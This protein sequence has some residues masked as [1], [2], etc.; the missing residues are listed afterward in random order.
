MLPLFCIRTGD[1]LHLRIIPG[2]SYTVELIRGPSGYG[3]SIR[4]GA[5]YNGMPLFILAIAPNGPATSLL[6]VG[7]E[8]LEIN[9]FPTTGLTHSEAVRLISQGGPSVKLRLRRNLTAGGLNDLFP[10]GNNGGPIGSGVAPSQPFSPSG[11]FIGRVG[12]PTTLPIGATLLHSPSGGGGGGGGGG[13]AGHH[14]PA[15]L[16]AAHSPTHAHTQVP[17]TPLQGSLTLNQSIPSPSVSSSLII[18]GG[19]GAEYLNY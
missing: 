8:I 17:F 2:D 14:P 3:F 11:S 5:E 13:L 4:G 18:G 7:D 6:T 1:T 15:H 19:G 16:L 10:V 9:D 12:T